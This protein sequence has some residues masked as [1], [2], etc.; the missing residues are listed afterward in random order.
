MDLRER[1]V[2]VFIRV[3]SLII[4]FCEGVMIMGMVLLLMVNGCLMFMCMV[5]FIYNFIV[6]VVDDFA[7]AF[8]V[9]LFVKDIESDENKM[10][11]KVFI[12]KVM[13]VCE[14]V[15]YDE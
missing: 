5:K 12:E 2:K 7:D 10:F 8:K 13:V 1:F 15:M 6:C 3:F 4:F 14:V 9:I 11:V